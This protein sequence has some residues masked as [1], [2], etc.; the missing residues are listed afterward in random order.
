MIRS[1]GAVGLFGDCEAAD[2]CSFLSAVLSLTASPTPGLGAS[3]QW[4]DLGMRRYES[5][6]ETEAGLIP[7]INPPG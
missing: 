4:A 7:K 1:N 6:Y 3:E 2:M 5:R